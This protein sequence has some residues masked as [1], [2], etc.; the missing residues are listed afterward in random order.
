MIQGKPLVLFSIARNILCSILNEEEVTDVLNVNYNVAISKSNIENLAKRMYPNSLKRIRSKTVKNKFMQ[1][2]YYFELCNK[3]DFE[4]F[5]YT[6]FVFDSYRALEGVMRQF[7]FDIELDMQDFK[8][9]TNNGEIE[10][11]VLKCIKLKYNDYE[12]IVKYLKEFYNFY[13]K[14][15]KFFHIEKMNKLASLK[16][17]DVSPN[18]ASK[19]D[20]QA[21]I[22]D[23]LS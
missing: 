2:L 9:M 18:I 21:H 3:D 1:S 22:N 23:V 14:R 19:S 6:S 7:F 16:G 11:Y 4:M 5:N 20:A 15:N 10:D 12:P 13:T 17:I 8:I